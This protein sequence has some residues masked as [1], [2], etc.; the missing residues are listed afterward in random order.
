M[1][2]SSPDPGRDD[3]P[4]RITPDAV[5]GD[6]PASLLAW[7]SGNRE[8]VRTA[9]LRHGA[10]LFRGFGFREPAEFQ[11][12]VAVF[13]DLQS[14]RGGASQR[15]KVEGLV[16]T[17]TDMAAHYEIAQHHE[18]AYTPTMP[19]I[20]GFFCATPAATGGETPL[21]DARRV[22]SRL[23]EDLKRRFIEKGLRYVNNLPDRFGFGKSWQAQFESEDRGAVESV[24][25]ANGYEWTWKPDGGLR[26]E[27]LCDPLLPHPETGELLWVNQADHWHP[28]G[29][30][31]D[32]RARLAKLMAEEDFPMNVTHGD[33][34]PVAEADLSAVRSVIRSETVQF[35]WQQGDV[36]VCDNFLVSHGRRRFTGDRRIL[37]ALG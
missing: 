25:R 3:L 2:H 5:T 8:T 21:A 32:T 12:F 15:S 23:P 34:S 1:Q 36:L 18:S 22:T 24:L 33:G 30:Q 35:S 7:T 16:Y 31:G 37:V 26:T 14:Y 29:L 28:S 4:L 9:R 20:I 13:A 27:L 17:S 11:A 19:A 10:V 6:D